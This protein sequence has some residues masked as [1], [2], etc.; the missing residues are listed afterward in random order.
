MEGGS[1]WV[2]PDILFSGC[3][4]RRRLG[5]ATTDAT[6]DFSRRVGFALQ[7]W[8]LEVLK[9]FYNNVQPIDILTMPLSFLLAFPREIRDH[10]YTYALASPSG[11]VTLSPWTVAVVHSLSLLRTCKQVHRECKD[12]I[13]AHNG[14]NVHEPTQLFHPSR[15]QRLPPVQHVTI[16]LELLDRDELEWMSVSLKALAGWPHSGNLRSI[17]LLAVKD[18]PRTLEEFN[19]EASMRTFGVLV[20]GRLY[21]SSTT[22]RRNLLINT[23]WPHFSNWGYRS[24]LRVMLLDPS[25][26]KEL[27]KEMHETFGGELHV[28]GQVCFK[29]G[30]MVGNGIDL[31]PLDGEIKIIPV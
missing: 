29:D 27:L 31:D 28:D 13:W 24:W 30:A 26:V 4:F 17:T 6:R 9:E 1:R 20:D 23:G 11:I 15:P 25:G 2:E 21:R 22:C 5:V 18:G 3:Y 10:V 19:E 14:L 7:P 12:I 8:Y 16:H